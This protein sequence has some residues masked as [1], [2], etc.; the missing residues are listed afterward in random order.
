MKKKIVTDKAPIPAGPYSQAI[1][2]ENRIYVAGQGPL[3]PETGKV[4]ETVEEQ[5][6]QV[7]TNIKNIL[8]AAQASMSDVVKVSAF[9]ADINDFDAYNKV[10]KEFFTEPYPVRTTIGSQLS[11]ILVEIDVIAEI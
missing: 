9:L 7:L 1:I 6:R 10:Y 11:G 4:P 5:T 3:N 2:N 8:E